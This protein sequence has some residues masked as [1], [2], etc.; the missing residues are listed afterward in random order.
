M[1]TLILC[2]EQKLEK[3]QNF[4]TELFNFYNFEKICISYI[5]EHVFILNGKMNIVV[6]SVY[7]CN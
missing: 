5:Y 4:S 3:Y 7:K 2:F 1:G 6:S